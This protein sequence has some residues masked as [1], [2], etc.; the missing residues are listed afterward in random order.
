MASASVGINHN[1]AGPVKNLGIFG[2]AIEDHHRLDIGSGFVEA[3]LKQETTG[4]KG[5]LPIGVALSAR[6]QNQF[7]LC[8]FGGLNGRGDHAKKGDHTQHQIT[9]F[10]SFHHYGRS[11]SI[12]QISGA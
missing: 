3:I 8:A 9:H 7:L 1:R 5:V 4:L 10:E 12:E 6:N 11:P 2:P